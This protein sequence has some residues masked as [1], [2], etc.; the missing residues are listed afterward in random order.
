MS[1]NICFQTVEPG[2]TDAS[3]VLAIQEQ[4]KKFFFVPFSALEGALIRRQV[5]A[6]CI[7]SKVV[8]YV[9]SV[10]RSGVV[11]IKYL[12]VD[13]SFAKRGI[14][15]ALVDHVKNCNSDAYSIQLSCRTDYPAWAFWKRN[16]FRILRDRN[17]RAQAGSTLTDFSFDLSP[18]PLFDESHLQSRLPRVAVDTN[19]FFDIVQQARPHHQE[20]SG[21][22]ADW[23]A[24]E[25]ELCVTDA[26]REDLSR[27][28]CGDTL[29]QDWPIVQADSSS[30]RSALSKIQEILGAGN[31]DQDRS[32]RHHLAHAVAENCEAFITRDGFL[33]EHSDELYDRFGITLQR[34]SDFIVSADTILNG[35]RYDRHDL[36]S[37]GLSKQRMKASVQS[38]LC[39]FRRATEKESA[40]RAKLQSL[41]AHPH[42]S[43]VLSIASQNGIEGLVAFK[44]S[45]SVIS[46]ELFRYSSS[47]NGMRRSRSLVRYMLSI[48]S[49]SS[50]NV[51]VIVVRDISDLNKHSD[52]LAEAGFYPSNDGPVKVSLPGIWDVEGAQAVLQDLRSQGY[53]V[54]SVVD[55]F[56]GQREMLEDPSILL[57]LEH[58]IFPGKLHSGGRVRSLIVP[59]K[60]RWARALFDP[61]LGARELWEEDADLLL[62]PVSVYYSASKVNVCSGRLLWYVSHNESFPGS[63]SLRACSQLT[64]RVQ[65]IPIN[66]Y[67]TF[68]HFGI[69]TL[70]DVT[71][72]SKSND[73]IALQFRDTELFKN[74]V[75]L[76]D[77]RKLLDDEGQD[78]QWPI[79]IPED[80]FFELYKHGTC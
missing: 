23:F 74:P 35:D 57:A 71:A 78:F 17:G 22:L 32:D 61:N 54:S 79:M 49:T 69:Y 48:I 62:N 1:H 80:S 38:N 42:D 51:S 36:T 30:F 47:I 16:D 8:G 52:A 43:T 13:Q 19:I 39:F 26:I 27:G 6:A 56:K 44:Q 31:N 25:F 40:L 64:D 68:R 14:G 5:T 77:V 37:I 34:P 46:V 60:P 55:W 11:R 21:L 33:I 53:P 65:D 20:S 73:V 28:G 50:P 3:M 45:G 70:N 12:A 72:L 29:L 67:R 24:S 9:W 4:Y 75:S 58:A 76:N 59:I 15:R 18:Y 41:I 2:T 63:K 10:R 7:N 66:L